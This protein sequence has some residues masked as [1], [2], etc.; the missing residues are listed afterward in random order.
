M[1]S[2][3]KI[4]KPGISPTDETI[5]GPAA[6]N[7][8]PLLHQSL[9]RCKQ[10]LP[11]SIYRSLESAA[12][13]ALE[14]AVLA[15][16]TGPQSTMLSSASIINGAVTDRQ[17]RRKADNVCRSLTDLCISLCE[18]KL[19]LASGGSQ[20]SF[21]QRPG[22]RGVGSSLNSPTGISPTIA[23]TRHTSLEPEPNPQSRLTPSRALDRVEARRASLMS[24][25]LS[26]NSSPRDSAPP[27]QLDSAASA[28]ATPSP[29]EVPKPTR[30]GTSLMRTRWR[31]AADDEDEDPAQRPVSRATTDIGTS[32]RKRV[33]RL[34]GGF[35]NS[36]GDREYTSQHPLPTIPS[37]PNLPKPTPLQRM[38]GTTLAKDEA[39]SAP[40]SL[41]RERTQKYL[42]RDGEPMYLTPDASTDDERNVR[43]RSLG[44]YSSGRSGLGLGRKS[45]L[46]RRS[47]AAGGN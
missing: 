32:F 18:G 5:G 6:A 16:A 22:S 25:T 47:V 34:S 43:R 12:S 23:Y 28:V 37:N 4:T 17:L 7:I 11:A 15:G 38:G 24:I 31:A 39:N 19:D 1:S 9:A 35:L 26:S 30:T 46:S 10:S 44:L 42:N 3:P 8:H 45:S 20:A 40:S 41:Q 27:K 2:S 33:N 29:R 13:D 21:A 36:R 14:M